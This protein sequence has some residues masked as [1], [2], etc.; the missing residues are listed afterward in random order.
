VVN[1]S[2]VLAAWRALALV[3]AALLVVGCG[4]TPKPA[5]RAGGFYQ[6]DGPPDKSPADLART[7]D[8]V[9]RVE[10]FHPYA[11]RPYSALGRRYTPITDDRPFRQRGHASWYGRQF[12]GNRTASGERYDMFAMTAA[13]PTLPLPSYVRVTHR[14]SGASVIV[15]VNDRGPF[16]HDRVI[17]VS[18][19]AAVKL[20]IAAAG[21]GEVDVLRLTHADIRAGR[22]GQHGSGEADV[23][24]HEPRLPA[25]PRA[26]L[27]PPMSALTPVSVVPAADIAPPAHAGIGRWSVQLGAFGLSANAEALRARLALLLAQED[28]DLAAAAPLRVER[29]GGLYRVLAGAF[30]EREAAAALGRRLERALDRDTALLQR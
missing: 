8:A 3:A 14:K 15:R 4:S 11:N 25:S 2:S 10:P 21:T 30:A 27:P 9:P 26:P 28:G 1:R 29:D 7:P 22:L 19:A 17:D 20:G 6:D 16:K 18:Y 5:P 24:T 23:A 12:H 13:H